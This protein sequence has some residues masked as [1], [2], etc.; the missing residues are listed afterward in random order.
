MRWLCLA[1][2]VLTIGCKGPASEDKPKDENL[3]LTEAQAA[4]TLVKIG[5]REITV[6]EFA[7]RLGSMSPY[8]RAR[9]DS[10]E[11]RR[12]YLE[13]FIR[14]EL[15]VAEAKRL[16]YDKEPTIARAR[17]DALVQALIKQEIDDKITLGSVTKDE[18]RA[19]YQSHPQEYNRPAQVRASHIVLSDK[20]KA[21]KVLNKIKGKRD[22]EAFRALA[23]EY[24]GGDGDLGFFD[25]SGKGDPDSAIRAAA[26]NL[27]SPGDVHSKL[28]K[29]GQ[30]F[31]VVA[32]V[33]KRAR[34][35]RSFEEAERSIRHILLR[36]KKEARRKALIEE[37]K[38][39]ITVSIDY[40]ALKDL[41]ID[42]ATP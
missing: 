25:A 31:H 41:N 39:E 26:F 16:G 8:L 22:L 19:Y 9:F 17:R 27:K 30:G 20:A 6:G 11:R 36:N 2:V 1:A 35:K 10:A 3:G 24:N 23:K 42:T 7:E 38:K 15:L 12:E 29:T 5:E 32:L 37:L 40:D 13:S 33:A 14:F 28:V 21:Q 34:L 18:A 4:Q